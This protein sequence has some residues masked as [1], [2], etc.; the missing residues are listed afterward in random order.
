MHKGQPCI[1]QK[2]G[3]MS[4]PKSKNNKGY[5]PKKPKK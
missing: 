1:N 5:T 3:K 2:P 4:M